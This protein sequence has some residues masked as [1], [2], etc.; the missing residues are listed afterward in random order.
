MRDDE[1]LPDAG[2]SGPVE[3]FEATE[4][5]RGRLLAGLAV[6]GLGVFTFLALTLPEV[7]PPGWLEQLFGLAA[8]PPD[9]PRRLLGLLAGILIAAVGVFLLAV[10]RYSRGVRL[11]VSEQGLEYLDRHTWI[12]A[13][14]PEVQSLTEQVTPDGGR[15][16]TVA[17]VHGDF[18]FQTPTPT[19]PRR[20]QGREAPTPAV[21]RQQGREAPTPAL[22]HRR[23]GR[24]APT[25][26]IPRQQGREALPAADRLA[27]LIRRR[28]E[29]DSHD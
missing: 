13:A 7:F 28:V 1:T 15:A 5:S 4:T 9:L 16:Y 10:A 6:I 21:P 29:E 12:V 19:L 27:A 18:R 25:L 11:I 20:R 2:S 26:A 14:W 24:E 3:V 17:T 22:P 23:Q 8:S